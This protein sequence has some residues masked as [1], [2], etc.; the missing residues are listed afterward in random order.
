[1]AVGAISASTAER[2][3]LAAKSGDYVCPVCKM[4]NREIAEKHMKPLEESDGSELR[5]ASEEMSL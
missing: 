4:S 3:A 1:M 2:K 5:K